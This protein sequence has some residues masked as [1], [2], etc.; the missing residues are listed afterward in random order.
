MNNVA[1]MSKDSGDASAQKEIAELRDEMIRNYPDMIRATAKK[2]VKFRKPD[3]SFSYLQNRT[4]HIA[5]DMPIAVYGTNEGDV[6]ATNIC[7]G[8][9]LGHIFAILNQ[10][11]I[12]FFGEADRLRFIAIIE[13]KERNNDE[14]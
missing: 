4:S 8:G 5:N 2:L 13:E 14:K 12:P 9:I 1:R 11:M 3:G 6:D 10:E 7:C